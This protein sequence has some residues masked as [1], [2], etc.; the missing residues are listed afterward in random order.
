M[1]QTTDRQTDRP[2]YGEMCRNCISGIASA[3]SA[4]LPYNNNN[5]NNNNN[6]KTFVERR[7]AVA[8][9]ALK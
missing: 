8:S 9:E 1:C 7:S 3:A 2:R 5:N 4:I 6:N